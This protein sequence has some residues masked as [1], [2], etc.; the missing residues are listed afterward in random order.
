MG[1]E[2]NI[3]GSLA[4]VQRMPGGC[5]KQTGLR[6][7][8][9]VV[10]WRSGLDGSSSGILRSRLFKDVE[11]IHCLGEV[12]W[13][14]GCGRGVFRW[15]CFHMPSPQ[16]SKLWLVGQDFLGG[17]LMNSGFGRGRSSGWEALS[18]A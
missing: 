4:G 2:T 10:V 13:L 1:L 11:G 18:W 9:E 15:V 17:T 16:Y 7:V 5:E 6:G 12:G 8:K 14:R 3:L